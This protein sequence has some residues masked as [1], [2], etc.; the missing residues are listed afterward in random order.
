MTDY[1]TTVAGEK[2]V[3]HVLPPVMAAPRFERWLARAEGAV[4]GLDVET[5]AIEDGSGAT[6]FNRAKKMRSIQFGGFRTAWCLDPHD[7][8]WRPHIEKALSDKAL[9][10]VS[11]T[12]YDPLWCHR[13]FGVDLAQEGRCIDTIV[14]ASL[15]FP[16]ER[17]PKDL[18]TLTGKHIDGGLIEAE[19]AL[20]ERFRELAPAIPTGKIKKDGEPA[21]RRL[22]GKALAAWGFENIDLHD[23]AF[24]RYAGLDAVY[25]RRLLP[26]LAAKLRDVRER[27]LSRRE[28]HIARLATSMQWRGHRVD[29]ERTRA[30][31]ADVGG[32]YD[33][34]DARLFERLGFTP[35][36]PRVKDWLAEV[37]VE[38]TV[39]TDTGA[40]SITKD[41]LP[42]LL[43]RYGRSRE[44]GP[45][46]RDLAVLSKHS[47]LRSN[48]TQIL[49]AA[50]E[51][52]FVHPSIRT[53]QAVTGRMSITGPAMQTFKKDS[54]DGDGLSEDEVNRLRGCFIAREGC[55][56]VG[57]DYDSQE[58]RIAAAYSRDRALLAIVRDG[59]NQHDQTA[60]MVFGA[61]FTPEQ[62]HFA[63]TLNFAQQYGA[64]P[65][66]IGDSLG[67]PR[68]KGPADPKRGKP[69]NPK[70]Q[71]MWEG[72]RSAYAGLVAWTDEMAEH[73]VVVNPWGRRIPRDRGRPYA[74]GNYKIQGSGRD[75]LGDALVR[76][77]EAGWGLFLWLP[78][79]D[80]IVLEVPEDV[81]ERAAKELA[82]LMATE[83][84][85]I[86][87]TATAKIVGKRWG[88][89]EA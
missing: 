25:V 47:N 81:A 24:G 76:L 35:R 31:L 37:G 3:L 84:R 46:L 87:L 66:K 32:L 8:H 28:Q 21:V 78:I 62:R 48:L 1:Q 41:T 16:G 80:E 55:V 5:T 6:V 54:G 83:V 88:G 7:P 4:V 49:A 69:A 36:S 38:F 79:H 30:I 17:V 71:A 45:V 40:P 29:R 89:G 65:R 59:L 85:G 26:I 9:R 51:R 34:A 14:L 50:D 23:P 67:L 2:V 20:H 64:G 61:N 70:A 39:F 12:N 52:G 58:I 75:V 73:P 60:R 72:W 53:Q 33:K 43:A 68:G 10:F 74:N 19:E 13:E 15:L 42:A 63:K 56:F 77:D 86:P 22:T 11:H 44:A 18:K 82:E 57:A 27:K